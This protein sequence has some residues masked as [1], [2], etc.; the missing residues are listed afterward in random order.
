[1]GLE[2]LLIRFGVPAVFAGAAIEGDF[3]LILSGV[4]AHLGYFP[5]PVAI[6]AGALGSLAGDC[7]WYGFGRVRGSRFR[8]GGLYRRVGPRIERLA[9]RL[10][11]AQLLVTRF[12]YGTKSASMLFWG[13]HGL[14]FRRFLLYDAAGCLLGAGLFVGLGYLVSGSAAALIG[15]VRRVELWL[16]GALVVGIV[17]VLAIHLLAKRELHVDDAGTEGE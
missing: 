1:M 14:P 15:R 8:A 16:L 5:L 7:A 13:L 11:A 2:Q 3:V 4:V 12:I 9:R 17:L 10:G 6:A